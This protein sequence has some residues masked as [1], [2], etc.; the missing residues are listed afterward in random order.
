MDS[1]IE[2][3]IDKYGA[4]YPSAQYTYEIVDT[5]SSVMSSE[6]TDAIVSLMYTA[7]NGVQFIKTTTEISLL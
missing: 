1:A 4:D 6:N 3:F 7:M 2:K 5:P